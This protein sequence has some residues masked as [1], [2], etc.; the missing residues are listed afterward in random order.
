MALWH[1]SRMWTYDDYLSA[2]VVRQ[3]NHT[4]ERRGEAYFNA[5]V[6]IRPEIA[7][8]LQ[9]SEC[10]PLYHDS[11]IPAFKRKVEELWTRELHPAEKLTESKNGE[12]D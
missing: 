4:H 1:P 9:G 2:V 6:L 10:D 12:S 8:R 5:L 11:R 7:G 3:R